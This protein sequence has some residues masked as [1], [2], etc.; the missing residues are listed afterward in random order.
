MGL[1]QVPAIRWAS[2]M[3]RHFTEEIRRR[4]RHSA[5]SRN[6][7][8]DASAFH[9]GNPAKHAHRP[10]GLSEASMMPRHFTE[11]ITPRAAATQTTR[12]SFNDASAFHRGNRDGG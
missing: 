10:P 3:P 9:R 7:F 12:I 1:E 5:Q 4:W 8:N 2:M 11:E 6:G